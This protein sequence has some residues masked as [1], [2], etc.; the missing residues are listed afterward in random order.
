MN[1]PAYPEL[2]SRFVREVMASHVDGVRKHIERLAAANGGTLPCS[3]CGA[4]A[5]VYQTEM[6]GITIHP[7]LCFDKDD[8]RLVIAQTLRF[9][10]SAHV[11]QGASRDDR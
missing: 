6:P 8:H 1:Y 3:V 7:D 5:T 11:M 9:S 10:C 2:M 4:D